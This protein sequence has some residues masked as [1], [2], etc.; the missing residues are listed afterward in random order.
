MA[1]CESTR[2]AEEIVMTTHDEKARPP[3]PGKGADQAADDLRD[4]IMEVATVLSRD[5]AKAAVWY[6]GEPIACFGGKT[7]NQLIDEKRGEDLLLY[8]ASLE[9]GFAG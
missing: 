2:A 6:S 8:L 4:R 5:A 7:A 1:P 3:S 9:A